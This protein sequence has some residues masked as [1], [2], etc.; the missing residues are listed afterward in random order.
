M[1]PGLAKGQ[2]FDSTLVYTSSMRPS[3]L[4]AP[5]MP[6]LGSRAALPSVPADPLRLISGS[7]GSRWPS[8]G[9]IFNHHAL[10]SHSGHRRGQNPP[11]VAVLGSLFGW[12]TAGMKR[13]DNKVC[14]IQKEKG[15]ER[16]RMN[17]AESQRVWEDARDRHSRQA[18]NY[19]FPRQDVSC[20]A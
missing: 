3:K 14:T 15:G 13:Q 12:C 16:G 1:G 4:I 20:G 18:G 7:P 2:L 11:Y 8:Q 9:Q 6:V 5:L 19:I 17:Q 10:I